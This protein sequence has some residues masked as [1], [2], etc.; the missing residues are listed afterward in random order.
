[1]LQTLEGGFDQ[2][3]GQIGVACGDRLRAIWSWV[4]AERRLAAVAIG[5][6]GLT[7]ASFLG[8]YFVLFEFLSH[9]RPQWAVLGLVLVSV[10]APFGQSRVTALLAV[11]L[12][13]HL[14]PLLPYLTLSPAPL[15]G[16]GAELRLLVYN[17]HADNTRLADLRALLER[18]RPDIAVLTEVSPDLR[19]QLPALG[20]LYPHITR[21]FRVDAFEVYL[22]SRLAPHDVLVTREAH[23]RLPVTRARFC[24]EGAARC[25]T[26][27]ALHARKFRLLPPSNVYRDGPLRVAGRLAAEAGDGRVVIAG[28]LNTTPWSPIF[29]EL[30]AMS[31]TRDAA[32]GFAPWATFLSRNPLLGLAIDHVLVGPCVGVRDRRVADTLGSDHFPVV[33]DLTLLPCRPV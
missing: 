5:F 23:V 14:W 26:L 18:E 8:A 10:A 13:A 3:F 28:D 30:L 22:L 15:P 4:R 1:M 20:D 19:G 11:S 21:S 33:V 9:F 6:A 12:A 29:A 32:R 7:L 2:E 31:G 25:V 17:L 16:P 24:M 27:I